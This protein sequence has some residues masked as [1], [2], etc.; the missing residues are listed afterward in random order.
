L[1]AVLLLNIREKR[2]PDFKRSYQ[3]G[4]LPYRADQLF[5]SSGQEDQFIQ[6]VDSMARGAINPLTLLTLFSLPLTVYKTMSRNAT[7]A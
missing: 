5:D 7:V 3:P 1:F 2:V 4:I 6:K